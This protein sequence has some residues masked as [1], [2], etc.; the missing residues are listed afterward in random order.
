[1]KTRLLL[2]TSAFSFIGFLIPTWF[3]LANMQNVQPAPA[4][5]LILF[6]IFIYFGTKLYFPTALK[7]INKHFQVISNKKFF[8]P[9]VLLIITIVGVA[10]RLFFR[11][12][13]SYEPVSDPMTFFNSAQAIAN[14]SG[15]LGNNY[16]AFQPYLSAYNNTLGVVMRIITDPWLATIVLNTL[17]DTI[18]AFLLFVLLKQL[19]GTSSRIPVL[20]YGI[21]MVSP[22]N[23]VFSVSSLPIIV[24]NFFVI[25]TILISYLLIKQI[26]NLKTK[27]VI[28]LTFTYGVITGLGNL[29]RPIFIVPIIALGIIFF[30]LYFSRKSA[31]LLKLSTLSI[32]TIIAVFTII[33][34]L[35]TAFVTK[36][37]GLPAAK[38]PSGWSMYVGSTYESGGEWRPYHNEE[39]KAICKTSLEENNFDEC[40]SLLRKQAVQRYKSYGIV[41]LL[42]LSVQKLYHQAEKQSYFYNAEH[43]IVGYTTSKTFHIINVS[44]TFFMLIIFLLSASILYRTAVFS[45]SYATNPFVLYCVLIMIGWFVSFV[46]VESAPR[47]STIIYPFFILFSAIKVPNRKDMNVYEK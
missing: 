38:N 3:L 6:L 34:G 14:G 12:R 25:S 39:R 27:N 10:C 17:F 35:N 9:A 41:G 5:A 37:T 36:Q 18:S 26:K 23:I 43:S 21:W 28:L 32:L 31:N 11:L 7:S 22:L 29:F 16:V 33:Q 40:H 19:R 20:G 44:M 15:Q 46:L 30:L 2:L 45:K 13:F 47:Y 4:A 8:I 24:V 1:M 42:K